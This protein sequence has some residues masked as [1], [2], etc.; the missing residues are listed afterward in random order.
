MK[1]LGLIAA[2]L[3]L[4]L[5]ASGQKV[6]DLP[7]KNPLA[8]SDLFLIYQPGVGGFKAT[9]VTVASNLSPYLTVTATVTNSVTSGSNL[10]TSNATSFAV[11]YGVSGL[12]NMQFFN[13]KQGTNMVLYRDG[14]NIVLNATGTGGGGSAVALPISSVQFNSNGV[15]QGSSAFTFTNG[16]VGADVF[17]ATNATFNNMTLTS[18][19]GPA[20]V[21]LGYQQLTNSIRRQTIYADAGCMIS[22][23]TGGATFSTEETSSPTNRM[24]DSYIFSGAITNLVQF[25]CAMP[26]NWDL[27]TIKM[28]LWT[29]N[30]NNIA[31]KTNVWAISASAIKTTSTITNIDWG[32]ELTITN[33]VS[34]AG[35]QAILTPA[36]P[37]LTV[38]N[39]PAAPGN[40]VWFRIRRIP[41]HPDDNDGGQAKLLGAWI[42]YGETMS[43]ASSW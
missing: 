26:L 17:N 43:E 40:L 9:L 28:K 27:S 32:T 36:T 42:Q 3:T 12:T 30:T 11:F 37:A 41:A 7:S 23:S 14:S 22:N 5:S 21:S 6:S 18:P 19:L 4:C 31:T 33:T 38:G 15:L 1:T 25:K 2:I 24:F 8:S 20:A 39:A 10:S 34:S 35:G 16:L 29:M 13:I